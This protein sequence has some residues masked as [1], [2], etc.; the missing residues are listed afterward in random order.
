M[1]VSVRN[2]QKKIDL[3]RDLRRALRRAVG[4]A[5]SAHG[6]PSEAEVAVT[7][8]DD[9]AIR[10]LNRDYRGVD[11]ATDVLSFALNEGGEVP[12]PPGPW[13]LV[14]G[15]VVIS[16]ERALAQGEEY[17]H[18]LGREACYLAV[19]GTLHLLGYEHD[20]GPGRRR[21]RDTEEEVLRSI[22]LERENP[23]PPRESP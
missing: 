10:R 23:R 21:M 8:V 16:L 1:P 6:L 4:L 22:D 15:D 11:R 18:G 19:H 9:A 13:R 3:G 17:G 12:E 14:L 7:L 2:R 20:T 5:L